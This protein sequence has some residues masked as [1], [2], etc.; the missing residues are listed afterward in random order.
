M[1]AQR[2][3]RSLRSNDR[4]MANFWFQKAF[5]RDPTH[6]EL[7]TLINILKHFGPKS[8]FACLGYS[9]EY[10]ERWGEGLPDREAVA[11]VSNAS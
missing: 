1:P 4:R 7:A 11:E 9:P 3:E 10:E 5:H 2:Q 6:D 8:F